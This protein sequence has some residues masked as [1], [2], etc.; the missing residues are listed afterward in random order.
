MREV[1]FCVPYP[2]SKSAYCKRYGLNSYWS[3][4]PWPVRKKDADDMHAVVAYALQAQ[5]ITRSLFERPVRITFWHDDNMDIDN[6]AVVEKLIVDA[7]KGWLL[8]NDGKRWYRERISKFH[9]MDCVRV[10]IEEIGK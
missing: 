9:D 4:K 2:R 5:G 7:L 3:G 8:E 1:E 6:H 10:R